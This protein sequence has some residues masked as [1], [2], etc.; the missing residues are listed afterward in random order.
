MGISGCTGRKAKSVEVAS[1]KCEPGQKPSQDGKTCIP[2]A[3]A[4][5]PPP[6]VGGPGPN[7][8]GIDETD[9]TDANSDTD[10]NG[11]AEGLGSGGADTDN[12]RHSGGSDSPN[13]QQISGSDDRSGSN[14]DAGG[15]TGGGGPTTS[16]TSQPKVRL[17]LNATDASYSLSF[18][19]TAG[20]SEVTYETAADLK[21]PD[22]KQLADATSREIS[23]TTNPPKVTIRFLVDISGKKLKCSLEFT[24]VK[25][26]DSE[27]R[28]PS[29]ID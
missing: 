21:V 20:V 23:L 4:V 7:T 24:D 28:S 5:T 12:D 15:A 27:E 18:T 11:N 19:S 6:P 9:G 10:G 26:G 3:P 25:P 17:S 29:C 22:E 16:A 1:K 13:P 14:D 2:V 8:G